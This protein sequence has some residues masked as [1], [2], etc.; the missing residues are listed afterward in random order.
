MDGSACR[1]MS[2]D[3]TEA[4]QGRQ[5]GDMGRGDEQDFRVPLTGTVFQPW[6]RTQGIR[7]RSSEAQS[8]W[9][10]LVVM[11]RKMKA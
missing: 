6:Q 4:R 3:E 9:R 2:N 10:F 1:Q 8:V 5:S 11:K 7:M